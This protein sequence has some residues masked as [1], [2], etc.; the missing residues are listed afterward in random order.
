MKYTINVAEVGGQIKG[1]L[2]GG[3]KERRGKKRG[4]AFNKGKEKN[5][6]KMKMRSY[7]LQVLLGPLFVS[8]SIAPRIQIPRAQ[9][10]PRTHSNSLEG[11]TLISLIFPPPSKFGEIKYCVFC[12]SPPIYLI[13]LL[14]FPHIAAIGPC[15]VLDTCLL[16]L[17]TLLCT[18]SYFIYN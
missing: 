12:Y 7:A 4:R 5:V 10:Y 11:L 8:V 15:I 16:P 18:L 14:F 13:Y 9:Q 1:R 2:A 17:I 3:W 6:G